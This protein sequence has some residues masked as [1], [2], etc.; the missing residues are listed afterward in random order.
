VIKNWFTADRVAGILGAQIALHSAT[1]K[2][3]MRFDIFDYSRAVLGLGS[4]LTFDARV[5]FYTDT[6][7]DV[8]L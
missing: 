5:S 7:F 6:S 2:E 1:E 4:F 3:L 8:I